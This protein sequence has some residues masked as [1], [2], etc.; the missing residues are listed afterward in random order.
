MTTTEIAS[1]ITN[2]DLLN[3]IED[4]FT[5]RH[6]AH[7]AVQT[8]LGQIIEIDGDDVVISR[9]DMTNAS[10]RV[11]GEWLTVSSETA[12]AIRDAIAAQANA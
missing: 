11:I 6:Q 7:E 3:D 4:Q 8:F 10:G 9:R 5:S 12:Q 1:Q 2:Y